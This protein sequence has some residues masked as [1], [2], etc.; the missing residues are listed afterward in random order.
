ME[1]TLGQPLR[2]SIAFALNPNEQ[3]MD[4]CVSLRSGPGDAWLPSV[5]R[6]SISVTGN[7][8]IIEGNTAIMDPLLSLRI[9]VDCPYTPDIVRDYT[10]I[11][12][13][14][15]PDTTPSVAPPALPAPA[16][17]TERRV[18]AAAEPVSAATPTVP[19]ADSSPLVTGA[20]YRIRTGDTASAIAAR[21]ADR[22]VSLAAAIDALVSANPD[23]FVDRDPN[24]ILAGSLLTIP[25]LDEIAT[26]ETV[27]APPVTARAAAAAAEPAPARAAP[28]APRPSLTPPVARVAPSAAPAPVAEPIEMPADVTEPAT[29]EAPVAAADT[30]D[31]ETVSVADTAP[32]EPSADTDELRPGDIILK[33]VAPVAAKPTPAVVAA[34]A[35]DGAG[36]SGW[37]QWLLYGGGAIALFGGLVFFGRDALARFRSRPIGPATG[38]AAVEEP[39]TAEVPKPVIDDVDF[40][41]DD[42]INSQ[43]ISLDADLDDGSGL[44]DSSPMDVAQ[45][46]TFDAI[47]ADTRELDLEI[48]AGAEAEPARVDTDI[49][50]PSHKIEE[51]DI[52]DSEIVPEADEYDMSMIVDATK[53]SMDDYDATAKD[54]QAFELDDNA[55][56]GEYSISDDTLAT[57][58]DLKA[59]ERDY[60][61]EF[62]MT[63][64]LNQEIADAAAELAA[65][66]DSDQLAETLETDPGLEPTAQM[67]T[68]SMDDDDAADTGEITARLI[69]DLPADAINDESADEDIT[70]KLAAAGADVTVEMPRD[71]GKRG[72]G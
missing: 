66:L 28:A 51:F 42:T 17:V 3:V 19:V 29:A 33:P 49:I 4:H 58:A 56:T 20:T 34:P 30:M 37:L 16:P 70:A 25:A 13:P 6:A 8:I 52:L 45:D 21:I 64:A 69:P 7:R 44:N 1:S 50:P 54:L 23:A 32:V 57:E 35:A 62:T 41:F 2:A 22:S 53:Q 67:P 9:V 71:R 59:L 38:R 18:A 14:V 60:E 31:H 11:V 65:K 72:D 55:A 63:Q 5:T 47:A 36:G 40:E 68:R 15:L 46:F 26:T 27:V 43:S 61:D 12:D 10:A 48:L 39:D 24:R